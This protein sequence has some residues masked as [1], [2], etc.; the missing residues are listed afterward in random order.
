MTTFLADGGEQNFNWRLAA[1]DAAI[2][3]GVAGF[4]T[5][6]G[7]SAAGVTTDPVASAIAAGIAFGVAFFGHLAA[8]RRKG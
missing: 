4:G 5:L 7:L 6:A 8:L 1:L 2:A 3:G